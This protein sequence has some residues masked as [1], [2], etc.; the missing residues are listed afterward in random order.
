MKIKSTERE[1]RCS[2][3]SV[4]QVYV[5][6]CAHPTVS[7]SS[8]SSISRERVQHRVHYAGD[9]PCL[10]QHGSAVADADDDLSSRRYGLS[11]ME[12]SGAAA[13]TLVFRSPV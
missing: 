6:V 13:I 3:H 7:F 4:S 8:S 5:C 1:T 11:A 12:V 2:F 10:S 9:R